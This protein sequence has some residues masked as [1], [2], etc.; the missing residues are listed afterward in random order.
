MFRLRSE[1]GGAGGSLPDHGP[2]AA[3]VSLGARGVDS[4]FVLLIKVPLVFS[5]LRSPDVE[6][7]G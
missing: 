2:S 4:L 3:E 7:F 5:N 1:V 6:E